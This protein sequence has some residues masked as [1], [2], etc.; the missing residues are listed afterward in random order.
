M[1]TY[2]TPGDCDD[3][4][5][6]RLPDTV[7]D[8]GSP[9]QYIA[10][11]KDGK[12]ILIQLGGGRFEAYVLSVKQHTPTHGGGWAS[13]TVTVRPTGRPLEDYYEDKEIG[14]RVR[15]AKQ[16]QGD[17]INVKLPLR[18]HKD[19]F[20]LA[21][22]FTTEQLNKLATE[23]LAHFAKSCSFA[24]LINRKYDETFIKKEKK[25]V[26]IR[27]K[28]YVAAAKVS[29]ELEQGQD[30]VS[31]KISLA[32]GSGTNT[33]GYGENTGRWTRK[34]LKGAVEHAEQILEAN[35]SQ[36]HVVIVKMVRI[37]RRKKAPLVV[38]VL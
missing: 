25:P 31:G 27:N 28:Y 29:T 2:A 3:Y 35:P 7:F 20:S 30:N 10:A 38:E 14:I 26:K 8:T 22:P 5:V 21:M 16:F 33:R 1:N 19:A 4:M 15:L 32:N 37:V 36:E 11:I 18:F 9:E 6:R 23:Q 12:P 13:A 24:S 17:K 34:D